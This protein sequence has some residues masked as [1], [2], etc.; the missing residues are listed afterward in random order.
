MTEILLAVLSDT[1][2]RSGL[3]FA[4]EYVRAQWP[5]ARILV[6]GSAQRVLEDH[7]YDEAL[8]HG[9]QPKRLLDS[10]ARLSENPWNRMLNLVGSPPE[11]AA[12]PDDWM[13][14][15]RSMLP[16]SGPITVAFPWQRKN[17]Q[18]QTSGRTYERR[19]H[20]SGRSATRYAG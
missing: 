10:L 15:L 14:L 3:C 8:A 6:L 2:G 16:E 18:A 9:F 7:L 12:C 11:T 5:S 4:A 1:L 13:S 19:E 17:P 20:R